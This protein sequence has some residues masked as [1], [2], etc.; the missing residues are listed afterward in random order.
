MEIRKMP[1]HPAVIPAQAGI[2]RFNCA[3]KS[4][5]VRKSKA[6]LIQESKTKNIC[7]NK[8][9]AANA[10]ILDSRFRGNGIK[11]RTRIINYARL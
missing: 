2:Q 8:T 6:K 3:A 7:Q 4:K 1:H 11:V 10:D 5:L 9:Y